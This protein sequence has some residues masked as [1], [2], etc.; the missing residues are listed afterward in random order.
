MNFIK[1]LVVAVREVCEEVLDIF[2][3][4][5]KPEVVQTKYKPAVVQRKPA[6]RP[7]QKIVEMPEKAT[8]TAKVAAKP[9][10]KKTM[11]AGK[12]VVAEKSWQPKVIAGGGGNHFVPLAKYS[13]LNVI[14]QGQLP[15]F[16]LGG[17][18]GVL[19]EAIARLKYRGEATLGKHFGTRLGRNW[20]EHMGNLELGVDIVPIPSHP[21]RVAERG[22]NQAELIGKAFAFKIGMKVVPALERI[23]Y[24]DSQVGQTAVERRQNVKGAFQCSFEHRPTKP[25]LLVDDVLT[26]GATLEEAARVLRSQGYEV[27]GAV[28]VATGRVSRMV[29]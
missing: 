26:S 10:A 23:K 6:A 27:F 25:V 18:E 29:A 9:V 8:A 15:V 14:W 16:Y 13:D 7:L 2:S 28:C 24:G 5:K 3:E 4:K 12:P 1:N 22:Y 11:V 19:K 17:Y 20:N 21:Q